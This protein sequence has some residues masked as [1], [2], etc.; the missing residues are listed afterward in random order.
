MMGDEEIRAKGDEAASYG[1]ELQN[2]RQSL[3]PAL[4]PERELDVLRQAAWLVEREFGAEVS[5]VP[6][7]EAAEDVAKKATPNRPAIRI[8]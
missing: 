3:T 4:A 7:D 6:A 8:D 1:Q 5:V 2:E